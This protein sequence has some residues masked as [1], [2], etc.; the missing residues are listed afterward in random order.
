MLTSTGDWLFCKSLTCICCWGLKPTSLTLAV[1]SASVPSKM[2]GQILQQHTRVYPTWMLNQLR[3]C[4]LVHF[5]FMWR[6][7]CPCF[8]SSLGLN[9]H[10]NVMYVNVH[11][12]MWTLLCS[13]IFSK[14]TVYPY[15]DVHYGPSHLPM[16][17]LSKFQWLKFW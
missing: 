14:H 13:R 2:Y 3:V 12:V 6:N 9:V 10:N 7:S 4:T 16:W 5:I 1:A 15:T 8:S 17:S 11:F